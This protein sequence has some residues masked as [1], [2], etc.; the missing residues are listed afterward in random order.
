[1]PLSYLT[2]REIGRTIGTS[3]KMMKIQLR[4]AFDKLGVWSRLKLA[5][6]LASHGGRS[7][8]A[9]PGA[10]PPGSH[11]RRRQTGGFS[12]RRLFMAQTLETKPM[13]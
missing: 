4:S 8:K 1:V 10:Q 5:M 13:S 2:N 9:K 7:W 12:A 3:E 6:Y 11:L